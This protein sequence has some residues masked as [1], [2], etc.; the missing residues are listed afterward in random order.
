MNKEMHC[1]VFGFLEFCFFPGCQLMHLDVKEIWCFC[2]L[3]S[4]LPVLSRQLP[5][6]TMGAKQENKKMQTGTK[7]DE[8]CLENVAA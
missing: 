7:V 5:S 3:Q 2:D 4:R 6:E 8:I 1:F